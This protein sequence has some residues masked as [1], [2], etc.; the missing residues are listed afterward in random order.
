M[1]I[2]PVRAAAHGELILQLGAERIQPGG[3]IE[4]RGDLGMGE[5]FQIALISKADGSRRPIATIP[6]TEEGHFQSYVTVPADVTPGDY[7][8]EASFDL[9]VVRAPLTVAGT[10]VEAGGEGLDQA[11]G[12]LLPM[13]SGAAAPAVSAP[14]AVAPGDT[15]GRVGRSP[16]DGL[17][18]VMAAIVGAGLLVGG[19]RLARRQ[20]GAVPA[21]RIVDP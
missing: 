10:P 1:I 6:A 14:S 2:G 8:V 19:M 16:V 21:G 7:L 9:V 15:T 5:R 4:V 17:I 11:D 20:R 3:A 12:L 13:P 18:V